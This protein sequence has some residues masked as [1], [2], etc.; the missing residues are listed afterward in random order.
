MSAPAAAD[1]SLMAAEDGRGVV[2]ASG[3][4]VLPGISS[5]W[6]W[7]IVPGN[8]WR[9]ATIPSKAATAILVHLYAIFAV[10]HALH[11]SLTKIVYISYI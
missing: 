8:T 10:S 4:E 6:Q 1:V 9:Q 11:R 3:P 7:E 2:S 5:T